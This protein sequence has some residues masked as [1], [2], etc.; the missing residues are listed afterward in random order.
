MSR[1]DSNKHTEAGVCRASGQ[2]EPLL[3]FP[4]A[5]V[6]AVRSG[7][8]E[9]ESDLLDGH[10][11][12]MV[13][14][15]FDKDRSRAD[16]VF[17][18]AEV[19]GKA[20]RL[21]EAEQCYRKLLDT[22][23]NAA[24]YSK[25]GCL[26]QY[27]GRLS[28]ALEYQAKAVEVGTDR[29]E[30]WANYARALMETGKMAEG[31]EL[32]EKVLKEMPGNSQARS[33]FLLR[34]HQ[35]PHL[36]RQTL[37]DEHKR[38][39]RIHAPAHPAKTE[40]ENEPEPDRILRIGYISPDFRRHSVAY[41]FE[42]ILEGHDRTDVEVYGYGNVEF[43]DEI[44]E[45]LI[46][47]FDYYR[48]IRNLN[49]EATAEL[50]ERDQIDILVDLAGHVGDNRLL[51]M[52]RKPSPIQVTYLGYP[53]TTGL[54]AIDYR[55]TD[56]LADPPDLGAQRFYTEE[57]A[58]LPD[59]F[60]CYRPPDFAAPISPLPAADADLLTFGSFNNGCKI[61]PPLIK[62]W[63]DIL[64][65]NPNSRLLL[66]IKGGDDPLIS[67]NYLDR[68]EKAGM[69]CARVDIIGWKTPAEHLRAYAQMDIALDTYPYNGTT[70]TCEALWMGVPV[71]SLV[72]ECHPSRVGLSILTRLG[73]EFF[74][75]STP[76]E[77]VDK[78]TALATNLPALA[79]IRSTMRARIATSGLCYA[80]GFARQ[81]EAAYRKMW[82]RW[83]QLGSSRRRKPCELETMIECPE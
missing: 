81:I 46:E 26:F 41:F 78:A 20:G 1:D 79:R 53:D 65:A 70:T 10:A 44:T 8:I 74:A 67:A 27:S 82:Y 25:L 30:L 12:E 56:V 28:Q 18:L 61:N 75:A 29:P 31:I 71:I 21:K 43:P 38:W 36:D 52:A 68:F 60:L 4:A 39:A 34:L 11:V 64:R 35:M 63:A 37:F 33:N 62:A 24:V 13:L 49:D 15:I 47:K 6:A 19:L 57:L 17:R 14:E 48:N 2:E 58:F 76:R 5:A 55:L 66:K 59:G 22:G 45:R 23:P 73:L 42:P 54:T 72:G 50:I 40:H 32:L 69:N 3:E 7:R 80:R 9:Q 77:Y 51:V 83:C 16:F